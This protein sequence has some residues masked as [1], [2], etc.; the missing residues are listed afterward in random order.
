MV[1]FNNTENY[2]LYYFLLLLAFRQQFCLLTPSYTHVFFL[3]HSAS[4]PRMADHSS[5]Q[6]ASL[7]STV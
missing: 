6:Q 1:H 2:L 4:L 5:R 3:M 7:T